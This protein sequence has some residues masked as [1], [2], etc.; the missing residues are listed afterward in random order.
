MSKNKKRKGREGRIGV[1][2]KKIK[3]EER[4]GDEKKV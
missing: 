2:L 3:A 4:E 1:H